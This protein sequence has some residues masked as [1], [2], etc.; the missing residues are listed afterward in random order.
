M[1]VDPDGFNVVDGQC[2]VDHETDTFESFDLGIEEQVCCSAIFALYCL[3]EATRHGHRESLHHGVSITH[4]FHFLIRNLKFV[5][6]LLSNRSSS[7]R[8]SLWRR[9]P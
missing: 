2:V 5:F 3:M 8:Q 1:V 6:N 7:L 4:Y 9:L